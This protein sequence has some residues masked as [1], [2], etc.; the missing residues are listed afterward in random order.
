VSDEPTDAQ[1]AGV[2]Y[3]A[4]TGDLEGAVDIAKTKPTQDGRR[5]L[6]NEDSRWKFSDEELSVVGEAMG[7][8]DREQGLSRLASEF[9]DEVEHER[10]RR[11]EEKRAPTYR[12]PGYYVDV[13]SGTVLHVVGQAMIDCVPCLLVG[14][15]ME[16]PSL[17]SLPA[18]TIEERDEGGRRRYEYSAVHP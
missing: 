2:I 1:V 5:K 15:S 13:A 10:R 17:W 6:S 14:S 4:L 3:G 12:G 16:D 8:L 7:A 18:H 11:E 9:F